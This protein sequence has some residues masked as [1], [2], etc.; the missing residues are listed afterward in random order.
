MLFTDFSTNYEI[1]V[2]PELPGTGNWGITEVYVPHGFKPRPIGGHLILKLK[3]GDAWQVWHVASTENSEVWATPD[4]DRILIVGLEGLL[5]V[6]VKDPESVIQIKQ[7]GLQVRPVKERGMLLL[8]DYFGVMALDSSGI[9]WQ[10][11]GLV[12]D[13]LAI[14]AIE[15]NSIRCTGFSLRDIDEKVRIVLDLTTGAVVHED[16][17]ARRGVYL[18][19]I[20]SRLASITKRSAR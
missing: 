10:A 7:Y 8:H 18:R 15:G 14:T 6:S 19:S 9:R 3:I 17:P 13:D 5:Y 20:R 1:V 2:N 11:P 4:P 12:D 16:K